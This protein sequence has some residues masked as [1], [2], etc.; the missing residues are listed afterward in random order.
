MKNF[1]TIFHDKVMFCFEKPPQ[2]GT[3]FFL[4]VTLEISDQQMV[5]RAIVVG[6]GTF[7]I[8][9]IIGISVILLDKLT[10]DVQY[11]NTVH[12]ALIFFNLYILF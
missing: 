5:Q 4:I 10:Y 6:K 7:V 9:I 3:I 1:E 11:G 12:T 2:T 8:I